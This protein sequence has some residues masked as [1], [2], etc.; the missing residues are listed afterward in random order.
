MRIS[1]C[2]SD[3]CSSDLDFLQHVGQRNDSPPR[4]MAALLGRYLVFELNG[5]H[6][7]GLVAPDRP[8][9]IDE[10]AKSRIGIRYERS[11]ERRVGK[12]CVRTCRY[13]WSTYH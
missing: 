8:A 13:R 7:R 4:S 5:L 10:A 12:E 9:Q 6:A 3:V 11:E 2:S 1:D